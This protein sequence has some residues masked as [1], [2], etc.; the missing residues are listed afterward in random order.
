MRVKH[1]FFPH[2][3]VTEPYPEPKPLVWVWRR[4]VLHHG[5]EAPLEDAQLNA[6]GAVAEPL[7]LV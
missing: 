4:V 5:Q 7:G 3:F 1:I 2:Q 6:V